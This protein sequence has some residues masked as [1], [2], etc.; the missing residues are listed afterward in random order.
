MAGDQT[1]KGSAQAEVFDCSACG[2]RIQIRAAGHTVVIACSSC[3]S[4]VDALDKNHEILSRSKKAMSVIPLI[5]LG[6]RGKL[7]DVLWEVIG[8]MQRSDGSGQYFW[9]EYLLFN[10]QRGFLWLT[11]YDGHWNC[12]LMTTTKPTV[13]PNLR[14]ATHSEKNYRLFL[15]G[16]AKVTFVLGE[17]YWRIQ[18][19]ETVEVQ[20]YIS[21]PAILSCEKNEEEVIW[22]VGEYMDSKII[23]ETFQIPQSSMPYQ[24][25]VAPNQPSPYG[26][27]L[28]QVRKYGFQLVMLLFLI[29]LVAYLFARNEKVYD[30]TF[31]WDLQK[32]VFVTPA[33]EL[34]KALANLA[35]GLSAEITNNWL[36]I[37]GE[38]VNDGTGTIHPF[39]YGI[40]YYRGTDWTEGSR[41]GRKVLSSIPK[42]TY[43]LNFQVAGGEPVPSFKLNVR[44]DVP[45]WSNFIFSLVF[46]SLYPI[47]LWF[48]KISFEYSRWSTSDYSPYPSFDDE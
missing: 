9:R 7:H 33:F 8:F 39:E 29:Q 30:E 41:S 17:F 4:V 27:R 44:R 20:D 32:N 35:I 19:G 23:G 12:V 10:P 36:E 43:H 31:L 13:D 26:V 45:N 11:E 16:S 14:Q 34:K 24:T 1:E 22:S 40:E 28:P 25:G 6:Q 46:I 21:P 37:D 2:A 42:G 5:P 15:E 38:L 18:V 48:R 3:G 47:Y